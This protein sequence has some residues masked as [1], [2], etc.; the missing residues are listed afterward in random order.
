[1]EI[2][3]NDNFGLS[4]EYLSMVKCHLQKC[5][6][7]SGVDYVIKICFFGCCCLNKAS[8][9]EC[10]HF[11]PVCWA[12]QWRTEYTGIPIDGAVMQ[13]GSEVIGRVCLYITHDWPSLHARLCFNRTIQIKFM[14]KSTCKWH[15]LITMIKLAWSKLEQNIWSR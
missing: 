2:I 11:H 4:K 1:M 8:S 6:I 14:V 3:T 13:V 15:I 5:R 12:M 9:S 7:V 10:K